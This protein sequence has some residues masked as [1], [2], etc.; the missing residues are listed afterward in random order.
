MIRAA[1]AALLLAGLIGCAGPPAEPT[2]TD[3]D[4]PW[5]IQLG[6][7]RYLESVGPYETWLQDEGVPAWT[8]GRSTRDD[9]RWFEVRAGAAASRGELAGLANDLRAL[10][11]VDLQA[12]DRHVRASE[13]FDDLSDYRLYGYEAERIRAQLGPAL[14]ELAAAFPCHPRFELVSFHAAHLVPELTTE[15]RGLVR[16]E[17]LHEVVAGLA[18]SDLEASPVLGRAVYR[19][20]VT[21]LELVVDLV[22]RTPLPDVSVLGASTRALHGPGADWLSRPLADPG[23]SFEDG[24]QPVWLA[25]TGGGERVAM[26]HAGRAGA[27]ELV[28]ELFDRELCDG[29]VFSSAALWRPLGVL[30]GAFEPGDVPVAV[31]TGILGELYVASKGGASW[32][33][34]MKGRWEYTGWFVARGEDLWTASVFDLETSEH[35]EEVHGRLYGGNMAQAWSSF[36]NEWAKDMGWDAVYRTRV[37]GVS[38][39]YVDMY[40]LDRHKELNFNEG[41]FIFAF[42]SWVLDPD[43]LLMED[44]V[45][46]ASRLPLLGGG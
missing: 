27:W 23:W 17:G 5:S 8:V 10:G 11:F 38:A 35:A 6:A 42:G 44:M 43:P 16:P 21:G 19:D 45:A 18:D 26:V 33:R 36:G 30:P 39:W 40:R 46:R 13:E 37:R 12:D 1:P 22:W 20:L 24:L 14:H 29:G 25:W 9:G 32:A 7:F 28:P 3:V 4:H 41:P 34:R 15:M 31:G 2:P